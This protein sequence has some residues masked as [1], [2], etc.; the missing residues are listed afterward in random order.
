MEDRRDDNLP[1]FSQFAGGLLAELAECTTITGRIPGTGRAEKRLLTLAPLDWVYAG[2]AALAAVAAFSL[3]RFRN[4]D[5]ERIERRR[6]ERV[7]RIGRLGQCEIL[8]ILPADSPTSPAASHAWLNWL[9]P[10]KTSRPRGD[11]IVY[12]YMISGVTYETAQDLGGSAE[13]IRLPLPGQIASVKYDPANPSNSV[14]MV[15]SWLGPKTGPPKAAA[16]RKGK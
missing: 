9:I 7:E 8:E 1:R 6:C 5:P 4:R 15:G 14:L 13:Q 3:L 12:R 16:P 11:L 10:A 2:A